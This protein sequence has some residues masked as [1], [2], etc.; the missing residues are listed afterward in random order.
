[1]EAATP[2]LGLIPMHDSSHFS[3]THSPLVWNI[4]G[5]THDFLNGT[6]FLNWTYQHILGHHPYTNIADADPDIV[7]TDPGVR[8]IKPNQ[9]WYVNYIRQ[10]LFVPILYA[11]LAVKTRFQDPVLLY[12]AKRNDT[13]RC[14]DPTMTQNIIFWGGKVGSP[15]H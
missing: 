3:M 5:A 9:A 14:N 1:M 6:S 12:T 15:L 4:L 10:E 7:T 11:F 8:R 2:Q 13:I